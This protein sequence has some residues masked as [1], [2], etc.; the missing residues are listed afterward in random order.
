MASA[1]LLEPPKP[2][3]A[4]ERPE[5][6]NRRWESLIPLPLDP[7]IYLQHSMQTCAVKP[8]GLAAATDEY[9]QL[10]S[11]TLLLRAD[12]TSTLKLAFPSFAPTWQS[13]SVETRKKHALI[14]L[15]EACS[16]SLNLNLSR[17]I[18]GDILTLGKLCN[19][20]NTVV[21][22]LQ[23]ITPK[24]DKDA[25][26]L[27]SFPGKSWDDF[28]KRQERLPADKTRE[29]VLA[30]MKVL[31]TKLIYY[32]LWF[33]MLSFL[34]VNRP[35]IMVQKHRATPRTEQE[36]HL[37]NQQKELR[38]MFLGKETAKNVALED[39]NAV[40]ARHSLRK[41][42]CYQCNKVQPTNPSDKEKFQ[43]CSR[44]WNELQRTV[45]YCSRTCQV[46]AYKTHKAICGKALDVKTATEA[47]SASVSI[48][49][50]GPVQIPPP[51]GGFKPSTHLLVHIYTLNNN[52]TKDFVVR[53]RGDVDSREEKDFTEID[54]PFTPV[55]TIFR[56]ARDKA[57]STGDR[58][59]I[60]NICHETLWFGMAS[61]ICVGW[62]L[63]ATFRQM[64]KEWEVGDFR[65]GILEMQ[66]R[67]FKDP[68]RRPPLMQGLHPQLWA[69]YI[70]ISPIDFNRRLETVI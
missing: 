66:D 51:V 40:L 62:D 70:N 1:T 7:T 61:T 11:G 57:M 44:C 54:C 25:K 20:W 24:D 17:M 21:D 35:P 50:V 2:Q 4:K 59:S 60:L 33:T 30:E 39:K 19:D 49:K 37:V 16:A 26:S 9:A 8:N 31:R 3:H 13:S 58:E 53:I 38:K 63:R 47:A 69:V 12:V 29:V 34:G 6:W 36:N 14:G 65:K 68:F 5:E 23:K 18:T 56:A 55:Q 42:H 10:L 45:T 27:Q 43:R 64:E 15:S 48:P 52:P 32:V 41:V 22:L 28:I 46:G 67:Q